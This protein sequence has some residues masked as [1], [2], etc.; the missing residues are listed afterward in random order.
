MKKI[1]VHPVVSWGV[2][3]FGLALSLLFVWKAYEITT[4]ITENQT[5]DFSVYHVSL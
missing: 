4:Y 3:A 2:L 1:M 5:E